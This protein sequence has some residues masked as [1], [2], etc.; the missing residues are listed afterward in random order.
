MA[1]QSIYYKRKTVGRQ[2]FVSVF[3]ATAIVSFLL[4]SYLGFPFMENVLMSCFVLLGAF[5]IAIFS[6]VS[7]SNR[8]AHP[9]VGMVSAAGY[10]A[11]T[12]FQQGSRH[13]AEATKPNL[14]RQLR[15]CKKCGQVMLAG[16]ST[17][18]KCGWYHN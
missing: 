5:G 16:I 7:A 4:L 14:D 8:V 11:P 2:V 1:V 17:C 3:V 12:A 18:P 13:Y 15:Y 10:T 9:H 6:S